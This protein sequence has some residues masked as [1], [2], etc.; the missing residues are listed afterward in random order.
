MNAD[1]L[2]ERFNFFQTA[3]AVSD[4][5]EAIRVATRFYGIDKF[6]VNRNARIHTKEGEANLHFALAFVGDAQIE[7]IQ[8]AGG[9]DGAYRRVL[10]NQGFA[11]RLHHF[12]HLT[13]DAAE[14][15]GIVAAVGFDF[16]KADIGGRRIQCVGNGFVLRRR[17]Q[18]VAGKGDDAEACLA[19]AERPGQNPVI[20][21]REIEIIHRAGD[22]EVR[23]GVEP[24]DEGQPLMAQIA[25]DL[26]IGAEAE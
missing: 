7:L 24:V 4:I 13:T 23:I 3:Y 17:E 18:P 12:G 6:Q 14:W 15:E 25:F 21:R 20:V 22:V 10:P 1:P 9:K 11:M 16:H 5:E 26:K 8:P 19:A 2:L